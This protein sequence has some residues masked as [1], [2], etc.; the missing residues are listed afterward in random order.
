MSQNKAR[1]FCAQRC[2]QELGPGLLV[3]LTFQ[4]IGKL[5]K[6]FY[7]Y[8]GHF[9]SVIRV[10]KS[11]PNDYLYYCSAKWRFYFYV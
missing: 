9:A 1:T 11:K 10:Y 6:F 7:A 3:G 2:G 5:R 8:L 4:T